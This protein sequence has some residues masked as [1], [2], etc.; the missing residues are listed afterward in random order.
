MSSPFVSEIKIFAGNFAPVGWALCNGQLLS[1]S[2]NTA[3]FSLIG[4]FYGGNGTSTFGLP[5]LQGMFPMFFGSG[6]G[7]TQR[8]LGEIGGAATVTLLS[9]QIPAHTHT[10]QAAI[11]GGLNT[12]TANVWGESKIGKGAINVY[13]PSGANN[14]AMNAAAILPIG[15]GGAHN[16]MPPYLCLTFIIA[17]Q[18]IFPARN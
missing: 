7:L 13:A 17:L 14:V 18:G 15:G 3:L 1:I 10:A 12:P 6:A 11:T 2:Q 4:T 16:N 9:N 8:S 5:N